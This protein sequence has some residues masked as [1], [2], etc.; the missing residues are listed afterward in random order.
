MNFKD[1]FSTQSADYA[2]FRPHYPRELYEFLFTHAPAKNIAWDVGTGNGQVAII[3]ATQFEKVIATDASENQIKHAIEHPRVTY[4]VSTAENSGIPD[5]IADL[6]TV[7]QALHWMDFEKFFDEIK[8]VGKKGCL[9]AA[10]GYRIHKIS[11]AIDV[12]TKK[13]DEELVGPYWPKERKLVDDSYNTI[14]FPFELIN[15]PEFHLSWKW[16]MHELLG[17]LNTW[18]STQRYIKDK[19]HNPVD[20]IEQDLLKAWGDPEEDREIVWPI[21]FKAGYL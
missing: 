7:G 9:F 15:A 17:Y 14:S 2:K 1:H 20:L 10:W 3:L 19:G 4:R 16:N 21:F 13:F 11:D 5:D 8:R 6:I 18:S 12:I